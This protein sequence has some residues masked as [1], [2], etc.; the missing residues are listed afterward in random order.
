M[1]RH[2]GGFDK[3]GERKSGNLGPIAESCNHWVAVSSEFQETAEF[4]DIPG[5]AY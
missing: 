5:Y 3:L 2:Q 4:F 1:T